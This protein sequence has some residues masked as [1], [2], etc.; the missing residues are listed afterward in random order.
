MLNIPLLLPAIFQSL[1]MPVCC[2]CVVWLQDPKG[3]QYH[4]SMKMTM[5]SY[6]AINSSECIAAAT[7]KPLGGYSVWSAIPQVPVTPASDRRP[8]LLVVSQMDS[9]DMFHDNVQVGVRCWEV[10]LASHVHA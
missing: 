5:T 4:A 1:L 7:C 2:L 6:A 10:Q 8:I 9:I 3:E